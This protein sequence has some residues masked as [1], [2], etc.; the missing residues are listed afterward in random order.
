MQ[1]LEA[2][3]WSDRP[4][5]VAEVPLELTRDGGRGEGGEAGASLG[6]VAASGLDETEHG[7]LDQVVQL[8]TTAL[9]TF[10]QA[11]G[12]ALVVEDDLLTEA[13]CLGGI[14]LAARLLQEASGAVVPALVDGC[15]AVGGHGHDERPPSFEE[16]QPATVTSRR[17]PPTNHRDH[18]D[19]MDECSDLGEIHMNTCRAGSVR[20]RSAGQG[21]GKAVTAPYDDENACIALD[22][23]LGRVVHT[24]GGTALGRIVDVLAD[25]QSRTPHWLVLR[26]RGLRPRHRAVPIAL[27]LESRGRLLV[28][29][30]TGQ[31]LDS[32]P[33]RLRGPLTSRDEIA[34]RA[35]WFTH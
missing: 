17:V 27:C 34:L 26:A 31:L 13:S 12:E 32:P 14:P 33:V 25:A 3:G 4:P 11:V 30:S 7:D 15:G 6:T 9:E 10:R 5:V 21:R 8:D 22:T 1:L 35:H 29:T 16:N 23:Y 2:P 19:A 18:R 24:A 28:P 20:T